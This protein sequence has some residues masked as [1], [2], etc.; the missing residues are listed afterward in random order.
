MWRKRSHVEAWWGGTNPI[1][2]VWI[3]DYIIYILSDY[4]VRMSYFCSP[5]L[6][7]FGHQTH[8]IAH[9]THI[10]YNWRTSKHITNQLR[11]PKVQIFF[12]LTYKNILKLSFWS[13]LLLK[14]HNITISLELD[15]FIFFV[16]Q[17]QLELEWFYE[18][19]TTKTMKLKLELLYN[20]KEKEKKI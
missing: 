13:F 17:Q 6:L 4:K 3:S 12:H 11:S 9:N 8:F 7:D 20:P 16:G 2:N 18:E 10:L 14:N 5:F 15:F 1:Y 19:I